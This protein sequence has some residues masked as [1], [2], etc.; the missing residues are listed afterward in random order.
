MDTSAP[1]SLVTGANR[2]IGR[3]TA[4]QL[5][6][7]GHTVLLCARDPQAAK[8]A[9]ATVPTMPT[10]SRVCRWLGLRCRA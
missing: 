5:A 7:L 6:E 10:G 4:R 9:A 2:G 1:I 3:E 8:N